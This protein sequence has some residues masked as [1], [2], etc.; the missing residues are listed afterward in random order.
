MDTNKKIEWILR[1]AV[2]GE[3]FGHAMFALQGKAQWAGWL[4]K[5]FGVGNA[6][7]LTILTV[8][9]VADIVV[10]LIMLLRPIRVVLLWAAFWGFATALVRPIVG[11]SFW[12]FIERFANWGA[13]LALLLVRGWPKNGREFVQ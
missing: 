4:I 11:E 5:L 13:P 2:A 3:F 8:I 6:T 9:G 7:A 10:A 1:V 12:D